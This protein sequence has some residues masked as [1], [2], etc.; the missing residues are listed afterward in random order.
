MPIYSF[1]LIFSIVML[2]YSN[3]L[4]RYMSKHE[5]QRNNQNK[6]NFLNDAFDEIEDSIQIINNGG[7]I[8]W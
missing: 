7:K 4:R 5:T 8:T 1:I 3:I 2:L 6:S